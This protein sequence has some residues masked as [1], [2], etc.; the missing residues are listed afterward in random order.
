MVKEDAVKHSVLNRVPTMLSRQAYLTY[1]G[2]K[3]SAA[4]TSILSPENF[5]V[6]GTYTLSTAATSN[7]DNPEVPVIN[8]LPK[9]SNSSIILFPEMDTTA[10]VPE[11]TTQCWDILKV[12][13]ESLMCSTSRMIVKHRGA[14]KTSIMPCTLL[15]Y[16]SAF[17]L[18][19]DLVTAN[20]TVQLNHP[21]CAKFCVLGGATCSPDLKN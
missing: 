13:P 14:D 2:S 5:A 12:A 7:P 20:K 10:D 3:T 16:D 4:N 1:L 19:R 18:G 8:P 6:A 11:I 17:E 15:P 21:H 9:R